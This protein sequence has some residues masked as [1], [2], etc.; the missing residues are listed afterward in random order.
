M[1]GFNYDLM[2]Y[3]SRQ[4]PI[5][6]IELKNQEN[7]DENLAV[8]FRKNIMLNNGYIRAPY[9]LLLS[10]KKGFLWKDINKNLEEL[11]T[12]NFNMGEVIEKYMPD[13]ENYW[14]KKSE[15]E[16]IVFKWLLE[17]SYLR[18]FPENP[19]EEE[20]AKIYFLQAIKGASVQMGEIQ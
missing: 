7:I 15:L 6:F 5:A 12:T 9:F 11:P 8:E 20:L 3:D 19:A 4:M 10:Q 17:L 16:M 13:K 18:E 1:Q 2:I 14:F